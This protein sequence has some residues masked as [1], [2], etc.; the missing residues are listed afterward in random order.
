MS[1]NSDL[2]EHLNESEIRFIIDNDINIR[3][4]D[5]NNDD[6]KRASQRLPGSAIESAVNLNDTDLNNLDE[7][8][9]KINVL[10]PKYP[11]NPLGC[12]KY[13]ESLGGC[14]KMC[15]DVLGDDA[16]ISSDAK[17]NFGCR[18]RSFISFFYKFP[19]IRWFI[20]KRGTLHKFMNCGCDCRWFERDVRPKRTFLSQYDCWTCFDNNGEILDFPLNDEMELIDMHSLMELNKKRYVKVHFL[21]PKKY[22]FNAH[23]AQR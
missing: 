19:S 16:Y 10:F 9:S 14:Q 1:K 22:Q 13:I 18:R 11:C 21:G 8:L 6:S 23:S 3:S 7:S 17:V 20:L 5:G 4:N 15:T 12:N 2:P